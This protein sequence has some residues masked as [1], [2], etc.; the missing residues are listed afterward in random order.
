MKSRTGGLRRAFMENQLIT[1][2]SQQQTKKD[3]EKEENIIE[4][5]TFFR[6]NWHIYADMVLEI[7]LHPFQKIML[8]LM[9]VSDTFFAI[10]SRGL[11]KTFIVGLA[12]II[13][14]LLYPYSEI[15]ITSSTIPQANKM[16]EDKIRDELIKKLSPYLLHLYKKEYIVI[17]KPDDGYIIDCIISGSSIRVLPA[18]ESSRGPRAT[19][20]IYEEARLIKKGMVDSVFEKMPHPRQAKF[21]LYPEYEN[22]KRWLEECQHIYITSARYKFEWFWDVFKKTFTKSI[23]D[24]RVRCNVFAG[25]IFTSIA[26]NLKTWVDYRNGKEGSEMDFRME[27]LNEMISEG[28]D[29]FF[30]LR[31]FKENQIIE[32]CFTPPTSGDIYTQKDL[33]NAVKKDD[34]IRLII[35]DYAFAN[36][37]SSQENDNTIILC[38]SLH[39]KKNRFERHVDYIEGWPASDSLG[40]ADRARE[41]FWDYQADYLIPDLRS[42]GEVLYNRMTMEWEHPERGVWWNK[43]GLTVLNDNSLHVVPDNKI[44]DLKE[45]TVDK[46][47]YPCIIPVVGT[48]ELNSVMWVELK[49]QLEC[50]NIKFLCTI[51]RYQEILEETG[52][53]FTLDARELGD[54]LVPY[55]QT[56]LLVL[57]AINLRAEY[58]DGKVKLSEPRSGTKDRAIC[59]SY[60]NYIASKLENQRNQ[61]L[62]SSDSIDYS[63]IQLVFS[64]TE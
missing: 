16:I 52:E 33:G 27:D 32:K 14:A 19:M 35:T 40:A 25:D 42:G 26:N 50:N 8:Y 12:A 30:S 53:Y 23:I 58:R 62:V 44:T 54:K 29:S 24:K 17:R 21:L 57:E 63:N 36:T 38:M 10:C 46:N 56:E 43:Q 6:R 48:S 60:G 59:L 47:A 11:S 61:N 22:N 1:T 55:G 20:L 51:E 2:Q 13:K 37:T 28:E 9:G 15:I 39:W 4:W 3:E 31:S 34:E 64:G 18:L 49:K 41:L 5:C 7:R 45:R